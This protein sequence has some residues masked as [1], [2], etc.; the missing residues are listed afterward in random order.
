MKVPAHWAWL[1]EDGRGRTTPVA[2]V[3]PARIEIVHPME[4]RTN[5]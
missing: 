2:L 5:R 4:R 1:P 3:R